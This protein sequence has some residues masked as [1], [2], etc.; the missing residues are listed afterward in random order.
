MRPMTV[1]FCLLIAS[2]AFAWEPVYTP[3]LAQVTPTKPVDVRQAQPRMMG[4]YEQGFQD[5]HQAGNQHSGKIGWFFIGFGNVPLMWLPWAVE[6]SYQPKPLIQAEE[7]YN[8][9]YKHG[10]RKGWK[11]AHK[12][13]YIAGTLVSTAIAGGVIIAAQ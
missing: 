7:E 1:L 8:S 9:G 3:L 11:N 2:L 12:N 4:F 10:Y 6:P 13:Y 5:G